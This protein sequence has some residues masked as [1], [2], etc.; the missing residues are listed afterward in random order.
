MVFY[1]YMHPEVFKDATAAAPYGMQTLIGILRGFVQNCCI[2]EFDDD[3]THTEIKKVIKELPEDFDRHT[4]KKLLVHLEKQ[5]RFV[6]C[7]A[8][9][10]SEEKSDLECVVRQADQELIQLV[11]IGSETEVDCGESEFKLARLATYNCTRF[12]EERSR[13]AG[14]G[15]TTPD[16]SLRNNEFMNRHF[17][18]ALKH[19]RCIQL[20]DR[21][22]GARFGDNYEYTIHE[23]VSWLGVT[24]TDP[25]GCRMTFHVGQADGHKSSYIKNELS[26]YKRVNLPDEMNI[27]VHYYSDLSHQR[28]ILTD[29]FAMGI[30]RGLDFLNKRSRMNRNVEINMKS[31]KEAQA[32][33]GSY[34][35]QLIGSDIIG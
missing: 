18:R 26:E 1:V 19:A 35:D 8:P 9:D 29:Q 24:L 32:L 5:N 16:D 2:A 30:D 28:F 12:E 27:E 33:L 14:E 15:S 31:R 7:L 17:L 34:K 23:F 22:A 4:L 13:L 6:Y 25:A 10:Y 21:L 11:L 20:C 3:R